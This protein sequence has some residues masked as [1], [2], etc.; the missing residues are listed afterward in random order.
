MSEMRHRLQ[1]AAR[2]GRMRG[3]EMDVLVILHDW[4][5]D[6]DF[7]RIKVSRIADEL[8]DNAR[9]TDA[10]RKSARANTAR[11]ISRLVDL[12]YLERGEVD[13]EDGSLRTFRLATPVRTCITRATS[14]A[15]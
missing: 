13:S 10:K 15:A 7:R 12:G 4:L 3:V 5:T 9:V 2:D 8:L 6:S 14:Q 11:A 1:R